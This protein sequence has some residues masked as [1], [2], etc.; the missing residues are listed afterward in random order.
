MTKKLKQEKNQR[1]MT[2]IHYFFE[3]LKI[4]L[5]EGEVDGFIVIPENFEEIE[6]L[7]ALKFYV[8]A[9]QARQASIIKQA[10]D[11]SL[12]SIE[13]KIRNISPLFLVELEDVK[14]RS[15]RYID[16]L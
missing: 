1:K 7:D 15:Q 6:N 14:A 11:R 2:F 12:V 3:N 5:Q 9:S 8:D 13:R 16:F 10:I 4:S